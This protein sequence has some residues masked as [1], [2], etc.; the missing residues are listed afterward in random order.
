[1]AE[2]TYDNLKIEMDK[3]KLATAT[4]QLAVMKSFKESVKT[5]LHNGFSDVI[6]SNR[7]KFTFND[8]QKNIGNIF[9]NNTK[10]FTKSSDKFSEKIASLPSKIGTA[11]SKWNPLKG[12]SNV[13]SDGFSKIKDTFSKWNP[14]SKISTNINKTKDKIKKFVGR[15]TE[16]LKAKY[17][18]NWWNPERVAIRQQ[19]AIQKYWKNQLKKEEKKAEKTGV[20][21]YNTPSITQG[22][23]LGTIAK[24]VT[25]IA[26]S[27]AFFF[28]GPGLGIALA[29]GL[30][31]PVLLLCAALLG[32]AYIICDTLKSLVPPI[33][34]IFKGFVDWMMNVFAEPVTRVLNSIAGVVES[35]LGIYTKV[36]TLIG[37]ILD[38]I[39]AFLDSPISIISDGVSSAVNGIT[40]TVSDLFKDDG[41]VHEGQDLNTMFFRMYQ[42]WTIDFF[43]PIRDGIVKLSSAE[44]QTSDFTKLY[45]LLQVG[46]ITPLF[47]RYKTFDE[48]AFNFFENASHK[49]VADQIALRRQENISKVINSIGNIASNIK[50]SFKTGWTTLKSKFT[51]D[52]QLPTTEL[53]VENNFQLLTKSFDEMKADS[54]KILS[55][56]NE[57]IIE[58]SKHRIQLGNVNTPEYVTTDSNL[59][60]VNV[61][62]NNDDDSRKEIVNLLKKMGEGVSHIV[63]NT[64]I[65]DSGVRKETATLWT[66]EG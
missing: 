20:P 54:I 44:N 28:N 10:T 46:F 64:A 41:K 29:I 19:R 47:N 34:D 42:E 49:M 16:T 4:S 14:F 9:K 66:L 65:T 6:K 63:H 31:P 48:K 40:S 11:F 57:S 35:V 21:T 18:E 52:K 30:T 32:V 39:I 51:N 56:I 43:M 38:K 53:T 59:Q 45:D 58:I 17:Y 5:Q 13:F 62:V 23:L 37:T 60:P 22:Q 55:E 50:D 27:V 26:K 15:D 7:E 33:I 25:K 12:I 24:A 61:V 3:A 8:L 2:T 1:M 36:Y